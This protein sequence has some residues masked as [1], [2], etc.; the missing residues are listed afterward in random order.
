MDPDDL[1][2]KPTAGIAVGDSLAT[3]SVAE[4]ERRLAALRG[5]IARV[6]QEVAR[7]K[8]MQAAAQ[9]VFKS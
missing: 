3:L 7:K 1:R 6:E 5:E 9:S 2:P 8:A 4:L